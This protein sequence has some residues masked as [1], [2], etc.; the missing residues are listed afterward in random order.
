MPEETENLQFDRSL[1]PQMRGIKIQM[2]EILWS[3]EWIEGA[4][5]LR[6]T[7]QSYYDRRLRE[8]REDGWQI[9]WQGGRWRLASTVKL[10]GNKRVYPNAKQ[11]RE[12]FARDNGRC[13]I[14]GIADE[15]IQYDHKVPL[16]RYGP[17]TVE[18]LQLL[19][20]ADNVEKRG[21]CRHC[22]LPTCD[23]CPYAYPELFAARLV[24]ALDNETAARLKA[25]SEASGIPDTVLAKAIIAERYKQS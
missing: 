3:G 9:E 7:G 22:V 20:R 8:M 23:G 14:C 11:K 13:R 10:P 2:L 17:T 6:L 25:E 1:F 5:I 21:A 4:E 19:C 12:V 15:T 24:I 18:N 16:E